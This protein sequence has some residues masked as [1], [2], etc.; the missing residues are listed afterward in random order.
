MYMTRQ[1]RFDKKT[2]V[3][4]ELIRRIESGQMSSGALLPGENLLAQEF[5]VSRGTLREALSELKR[6]N[7]IATQ[8]GVGSI[9]T[10]D[11]FSLD[12]HAGWAQAL[13]DTGAGVRT[14]ILR[15]VA[16]QRP[17]LEVRLGTSS[18][19]AL[20]R[21]RIAADGS[22]VSL[23]RALIPAVDGLEDLPQYGLLEDSLTVTMAAHGFIGEKG[24]QWIG[25][26]PLNSDD[27]AL[28]ARDPGTVFLKAV[29]TTFDRRARFMEH[30]ESLLDPMHFRLHLAFGSST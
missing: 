4:N 3:I 15:L 30:V 5:N 13:A 23:E 24:D 27:A 19:V 22:I 1:V 18:L 12:Q 8:T 25:A 21:R 11:G 17:D 20:D 28:L 26:E 6:R 2:Q 29:R 10:Y 7:F 14:E 16:V 9:V